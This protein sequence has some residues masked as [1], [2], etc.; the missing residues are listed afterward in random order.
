M[1]GEELDIVAL[2]PSSPAQRYL[3]AHYTAPFTSDQDSMRLDDAGDGSAWSAAN[4]RFNGYFREMVTRFEYDDA[5]VARHAR[6]YRLHPQQG[7][8]PRHQHP[9]GALSRIQSA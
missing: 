2:L 4:A 3:Q 9:D 5:R 1:T 7:S 8:R 6:Q